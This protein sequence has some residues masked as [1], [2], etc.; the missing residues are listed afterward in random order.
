MYTLCSDSHGLFIFIG[1]CGGDEVRCSNGYCIKHTIYCNGHNPCGNDSESCGDRTI[2]EPYSTTS[3]ILS[4]LIP[5]GL[6]VVGGA[7]AWGFFCRNKRCRNSEGSESQVMLND[8][9]IT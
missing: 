4:V 1:Q 6:L 8:I 5:V 9:I 3:I 2:S 7:I